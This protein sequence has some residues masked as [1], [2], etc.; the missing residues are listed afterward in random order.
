[1]GKMNNMKRLA[2]MVAIAGWI[3]KVFDGWDYDFKY[4]PD[5][6]G[7]GNCD[8]IT[9]QVQASKVYHLMQQGYFQEGSEIGGTKVMVKE[10]KQKKWH[11]WFLYEVAK[12]PKID[13][14][15]VVFDT[16]EQVEESLGERYGVG[17]EGVDCEGVDQVTYNQKRTDDQIAAFQFALGQML[18]TPRTTLIPGEGVYRHDFRPREFERWPSSNESQI[19]P[20][21]WI[22]I[23]KAKEERRVKEGNTD[24]NDS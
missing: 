2:L 4:V 16:P 5:H 9:K 21:A 17:N 7:H 20:V 3:N 24:G 13:V 12:Y 11:D 22:D 18:G 1:M 14:E 10:T 6:D 23:A 8:T 15:P 19:F